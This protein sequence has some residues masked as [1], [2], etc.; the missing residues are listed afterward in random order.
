VFLVW[1]DGR[2]EAAALAEAGLAW[3][4]EEHPN[5]FVPGTALERLCLSLV[6]AAGS[7]YCDAR[8]RV[9]MERYVAAWAASSTSMT[10]E[11]LELAHG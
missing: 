5:G 3:V 6:N 2:R 11:G 4:E 7:L 8:W 10:A 9:D 1:P